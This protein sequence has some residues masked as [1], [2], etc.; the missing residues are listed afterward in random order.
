MAK[1]KPTPTHKTP[2]IRATEFATELRRTLANVSFLASVLS[3]T[4]LSSLSADKLT[5]WLH[6]IK[7]DVDSA[8]EWGTALIDLVHAYEW[9]ASK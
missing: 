6:M 1:R 8:R 7:S 5:T 2:H 4:E 9:K 3:V